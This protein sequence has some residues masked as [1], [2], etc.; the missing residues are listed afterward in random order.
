MINN[1]VHSTAN[2]SREAFKLVNNN[3]IIVVILFTKLVLITNNKEIVVYTKTVDGV[4]GR[5]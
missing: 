3:F 5:L 2:Y 4:E 1:M